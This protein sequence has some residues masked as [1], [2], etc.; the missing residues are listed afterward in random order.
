MTVLSCLQQSV[1]NPIL[2]L[3]PM[4]LSQSLTHVQGGLPVALSVTDDFGNIVDPNVT[5][6][7]LQG[8][9]G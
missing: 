8:L 1:I 5:A 4:T 9:E 3:D 2:H 7:V 6:K